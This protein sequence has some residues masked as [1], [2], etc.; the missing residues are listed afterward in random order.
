MM[1]KIA[2]VFGL[3]VLILIAGFVILRPGDEAKESEISFEEN[4]QIE[5]W[6]LENDLNQYGDSKDTVYI[7][8]TPLFD[9]KTGESIDKYEYILRNHPNKPWLSQ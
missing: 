6:I 8:G 4:Q 7:G 9:E 5:A 2:L 3:V 1:N